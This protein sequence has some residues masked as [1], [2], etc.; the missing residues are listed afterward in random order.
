MTKTSTH[1]IKSNHLNTFPKY[2]IDY[3]VCFR[4]R[5]ETKLQPRRLVNICQTPIP[6]VHVFYLIQYLFKH[7]LNVFFCAELLITQIPQE[8]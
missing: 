5:V 1:G 3:R 8:D 4:Q 2:R 7:D 6:F